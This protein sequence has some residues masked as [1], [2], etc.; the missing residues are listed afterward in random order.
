VA[1]SFV[2]K[3]RSGLLCGVAAIKLSMN[4]S[5][6]D[7]ERSENALRCCYRLQYCCRGARKKRE[8]VGGQ[9]SEVRFK[10]STLE[11]TAG[12]IS[13]LNKD[14]CHPKT[15]AL[16]LLLALAAGLAHSSARG[17]GVFL[18]SGES[19]SFSF[20]SL[21]GTMTI[22]SSEFMIDIIPP[23]CAP[24]T[25][26]CG[27]GLIDSQVQVSTLPDE[28]W[29][30]IRFG[31]NPLDSGENLTV[32]LFENGVSDAPFFTQ[33]YAGPAATTLTI[34]GLSGWTDL[35]G[36]ARLTMQQG[37]VD[38]NDVTVWVV[39]SGTGYSGPAVVPEPS[40]PLLAALCASSA[41]G[42]R[43][44]R[45]RRKSSQTSTGTTN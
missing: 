44:F 25:G 20:N 12:L 8:E 40:I 42:V 43:A 7:R 18:S 45:H 21:P 33:S 14:A 5:R 6:S 9:E 24:Y 27:P 30:F 29:A 1:E 26:A 4:S 32:E 34:A 11:T 37:A 17:Q 2:P 13:V 10:G 28:S 41:F 19:A 35:Q 39:H 31:S 16:W 38:I 3:A 15:P 23:P 36:V 22:V